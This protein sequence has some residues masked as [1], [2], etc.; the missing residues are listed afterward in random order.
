MNNFLFASGIKARGGCW[1]ILRSM[2]IQSLHV[3][4]LAFLIEPWL[5]TESGALYTEFYTDACCS[6]NAFPQGARGI[7]VP[8]ISVLCYSWMHRIS[9]DLPMHL[10]SL[11]Y[12]YMQYHVDPICSNNT[13]LS[14]SHS[15]PWR[16]EACRRTLRHHIFAAFYRTFIHDTYT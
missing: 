6:S 13:N 8:T 4:I 11:L 3:S 1:L 14:C 9:S 10:C 16:P 12:L 15:P 2:A 5:A 7:R